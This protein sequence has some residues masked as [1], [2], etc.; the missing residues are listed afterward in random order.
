MVPNIL[1]WGCLEIWHP[2]DQSRIQYLYLIFFSFF[3][4]FLFYLT[5][6]C[7]ANMSLDTDKIPVHG[8]VNGSIVFHC[9]VHV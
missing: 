1:L 8:H 4:F 3:F 5:A 2:R 9:I 6:S 7:T